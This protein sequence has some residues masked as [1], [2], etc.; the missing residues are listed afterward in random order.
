MNYKS[1]RFWA[2]HCVL[3]AAE[4]S[5]NVQVGMVVTSGILLFRADVGRK[6][7]WGHQ[8][9]YGKVWLWPHGHPA[10]WCA[11]PR[12]QPQAPVQQQA[13]K[14]SLAAVARCLFSSHQPSRFFIPVP[15]SSEE[16]IIPPCL[17]RHLCCVFFSFPSLFPLCLMIL[18]LSFQTWIGYLNRFHIDKA[19]LLRADPFTYLFWYNCS[20]QELHLGSDL[21]V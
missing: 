18:F 11:V 7:T 19:V 15:S 1:D 4:R 12:W 21:W 14:I 9:M 6:G 5:V 8:E 3:P 16:K 2:H 17:Q 13:A 10:L 20:G